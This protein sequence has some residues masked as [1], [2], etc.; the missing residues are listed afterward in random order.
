MAEPQQEVWLPQ[1]LLGPGWF[2]LC[3]S[4]RPPCWVEK[5]KQCVINVAVDTAGRFRF[6]YFLE[7]RS[8]IVFCMSS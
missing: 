7:S 8:T 4:S 5:G 6:I 3:L 1:P 2:P